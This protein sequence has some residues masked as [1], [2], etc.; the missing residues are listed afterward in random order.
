[1]NRN[2]AR[3]GEKNRALHEGGVKT[4]LN[5]YNIITPDFMVV[6]NL[7][8][9]EKVQIGYPMVIKVCSPDI[10]HKTEVDGVK[11]NIGNSA[12]MHEAFRELRKNFATEQLLVEKMEKDGLEIIIGLIND[13]IFGL[14]IMVGLGGIFTEV[15]QDVSFRALPIDRENAEMMLSE[16]RAGKVFKCYRGKKIDTEAVVDLLLKVSLMGSELESIIDQLDLNPVIVYEDGYS[17]VDAKLMLKQP[18][19]INSERQ[20]YNPEEIKTL[21]YPESVAVVGASN[22]PQKFGHLIVKNIIAGGF[23]GKLYPVNPRAGDILGLQSY[24]SVSAIPD[25]IDLVITVVPFE[26]IL[27]VV[28][29]CR[30]KNIKNMAITTGGFEE[31]GVEGEKRAGTVINALKN[32]P[33]T[34]MLGPN[35]M[36]LINLN[37]NLCAAFAIESLLPDFVRGNIGLIAQSGSCASHFLQ[38][39]TDDGIGFSMMVPTGNKWDVDESDLIRFMNDDPSVSVIAAQLEGIQNGKRFFSAIKEKSKPLVLLKNGRTSLGVKAAKSHTAA[40]AT[41]EKILT[42][43]LKQYNVS[44]VETT[45]SFHDLCKAISLL[46]PV[47]GKNVLIVGTSGGIA[48]IASDQIEFARLNLPELSEANKDVMRTVMATH[49]LVGNPL[50]IASIEA[51]TFIRIAAT[52]NFDAYDLTWLLFADP[53]EKA[54]EAVRAFQQYSKKPVIVEFSGGGSVELA[55]KRKIVELGVPVFSSAERALPFLHY[56]SN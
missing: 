23:K 6:T 43:V 20:V 47:K 16:L 7:Q 18:A 34:R 24:P 26:S 2:H 12:E 19:A 17:V 11:L 35:M 56:F 44:Q 15:L 36:G 3:H 38:S 31:L 48:I 4:L 49:A 1:M 22:S 40:L 8:D 42:G 53:V 13:S 54:S 55:E 14:C 9:L 32:T 29:E 50:D 5:K 51:A 39:I 46:G 52:F 25:D 21:I 30:K 41:N 37:I 28:A 45:E 10:L 33:S 27:D